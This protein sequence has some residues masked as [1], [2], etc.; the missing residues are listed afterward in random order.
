MKKSLTYHITLF[1]IKLKGLKKTF[2]QAP[3]DYGKLRKEDIHKPNTSFFNKHLNEQFEV[4]KTVLSEIKPQNSSNRLLLFIHGGAFVSGPSKHHWDTIEEMAK[5]TN[6][7]IW[8]CD[9]PKAP[10]HKIAEISKNI[11]YVYDFAIKKFDPDD[12]TIIGD[13]VGGTLTTA[14]IQRLIEKEEPLPYQVILV[15]PVMDASFSNS[16]ID[17]IDGSDPMLSKKGVLSAKLMCAEHNNLRD[18]LISPI[19]GRFEKFPKTI[20]FLAENDITY[21]DQ[22]IL[23]QKLKESKANFEVTIGKGMPHIW[24][25]LPVMKEAKLALQN[26]IAILN[27]DNN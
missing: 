19:N 8:M 2:S 12:I 16:E 14:L 18:P 10:E 21:P 26:V 27:K 25:Y 7:T 9:Y 24:P 11:D 13:S 6:Y 17:E 1:V 3:I 4:L 22:Q 20:L 15:S 5:Q 23:I